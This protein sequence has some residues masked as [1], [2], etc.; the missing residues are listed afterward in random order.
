MV[1]AS[2]SARPAA[3]GRRRRRCPATPRAWRAPSSTPPATARWGSRGASTRPDTTPDRRRH[4]RSRWDARPADRDRRRRRR[5]RAPP[6]AG[7]RPAGRRAA[8]LQH[9]HQAST[10][11]SRRIAI[12]YRTAGRLVR[13][14]DDRRPDAVEHARGRAG[15]RRHR[16][17]RVGARPPGSTWSRSAPTGGSARSS[18]S[19]RRMG[20]QASSR[21]R[22]G[23]GGYAGV[24]QPS[25]GRKGERRCAQPLLGAPRPDAGHAFA[26]IRTVARPA[27]SCAASHRRRR[28]RPRDAGL[29]PG[30]L[31]RRRSVGTNG[32]TSA[33]LATSARPAGPAGATV[34]AA[35]TPVPRTLPLAAAKGRVALAW[36]S[37]AAAATWASRPPS[38][39]RRS[40]RR[41]PSRRFSDV[42]S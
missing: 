16:R 26:A 40:A 9:G 34:V 14:A 37:P 33:I 11:A 28:E 7:D 2:S 8:R 23:R 18:G 38:A 31:R 6:G 10:S 24:G 5:G 32:I 19:R 42:T 35:G 27:T 20:S 29:E 30:A 22:A 12:A 1:R 4:A 41:R 17:R 21:P 3:P 39:R 36:G 15:R 25:R 13:A